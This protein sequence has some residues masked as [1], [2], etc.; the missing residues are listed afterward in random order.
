M[1]EPDAFRFG[2]SKHRAQGPGCRAIDRGVAD[3]G[4]AV[5]DP[6]RTPPCDQLRHIGVGDVGQQFRVAKIID[7]PRQI[8]GRIIRAGM[9]LS[10]S[11]PI[12]RSD[13]VNFPA[14]RLHGAPPSVLPSRGRALALLLFR[15]AARDVQ[16]VE[17]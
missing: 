9:V 16:R 5:G 12:A 1:L 14:I 13:V 17:P 4:I 8:A 11:S 15:F 6:I 10:P 7:Q 3:E 2:E